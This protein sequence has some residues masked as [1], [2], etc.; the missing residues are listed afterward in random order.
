MSMEN[1]T[2][3]EI[4]DFLDGMGSKAEREITEKLIHSNAAMKKR[5][6]ELKTVH[7]FLQRQNRMEHPS[8]NFTDKVMTRLHEQ[9]SFT[10]LSPKNGLLLLIGLIV[11]SGLA[12][13]LVSSSSVNQWHTLLNLGQVPVKTDWIKLPTSIPFDV[14]LMLKIF[15]MLNI[16]I[17]FVLLDRTILRPIFQKRAERFS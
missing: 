11:A 6:E 7:T 3:N 14:K 13:M 10:F 2:D 9:S 4:L 12:I 16:V 1:L 8:K 5:M 17:G 15:V